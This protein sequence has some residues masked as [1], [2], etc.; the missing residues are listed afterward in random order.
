MTVHRTYYMLMLILIYWLREMPH[1]SRYL[2]YLP[3]ALHG[4]SSFY[5]SILITNVHFSNEYW[6]ICLM[7]ARKMEERCASKHIR[8]L[9]GYRCC[10]WCHRLSRRIKI[11]R[12]ISNSCFNLISTRRRFA[13]ECSISKLLLVGILDLRFRIEFKVRQ[14]DVNEIEKRAN[15]W[16]KMNGTLLVSTNATYGK[17]SDTNIWTVQQWDIHVN[18]ISCYRFIVFRMICSYFHSWEFPTT[19]SFDW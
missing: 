1:L 6:Y 16:G 8:R 4:D 19:A 5:R 2:F 11:N 18:S 3:F 12:F 7:I 14:A 17:L 9:I 15:G 10:E 13:V